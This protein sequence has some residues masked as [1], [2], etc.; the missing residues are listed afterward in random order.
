VHPVNALS[1]IS[2][3]PTKFACLANNHTLDYGY[4]GHRE[5]IEVL[6]RKNI[7]FTGA[8]DNL[9]EAQ[10]PALIEDEEFGVENIMVTSFAD[11]GCNEVDSK[12]D[13]LW[14]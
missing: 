2:T 10:K 8:G 4:Q 1:I 13:D 12:G 14:A 3:I 6:K 5:T 9:I 11:H 7:S